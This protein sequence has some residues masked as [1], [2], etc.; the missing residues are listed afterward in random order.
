MREVSLD[1]VV[2]KGIIEKNRKLILYIHFD[3]E[4]RKMIKMTI[5][6]YKFY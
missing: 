5:A 6:T 3:S 4:F 2:N 1:F